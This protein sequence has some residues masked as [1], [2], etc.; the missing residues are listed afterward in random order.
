MIPVL[1]SRHTGGGVAALHQRWLR[2]A[3][4]L[5]FSLHEMTQAQRNMFPPPGAQNA[6]RKPY[7]IYACEHIAFVR[8]SAARTTQGP[9]AGATLPH[10]LAC[11]CCYCSHSSNAVNSMHGWMEGRAGQRRQLRVP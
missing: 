7:T 2:S 5:W 6:Q 1:G 8:L 4:R 3:P 10:F 11:K 9:G